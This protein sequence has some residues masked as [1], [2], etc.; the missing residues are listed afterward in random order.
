MSKNR[1]EWLD[2]CKG[3]AIMLVVVGHI[4]TDFRSS[5]LFLDYS[6]LINKV[7]SLIYSF[8]MPLFFILSGFAFHI[9]YLTNR[10]EKKKKFKLQIMNNIYIYIYKLCTVDI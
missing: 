5:N 7:Y 2:C 6:I 4:T 1:I 9:A 3:F 10:E 8:H